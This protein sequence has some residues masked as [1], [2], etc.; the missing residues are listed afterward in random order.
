LTIVIVVEFGFCSAD[1]L[2][3]LLG[4]ADGRGTSY[5]DY[6]VDYVVDVTVCGVGQEVLMLEYREQTQETFANSEA[7]QPVAIN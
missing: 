2:S 3:K 1:F 4:F 7:I 6:F 5:G